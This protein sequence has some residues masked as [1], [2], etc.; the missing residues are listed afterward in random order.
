MLTERQEMTTNYQKMQN[1][2]QKMGTENQEITTEPK[3]MA[4]KQ[5]GMPTEANKTTKQAIRRG[6][7]SN[8]HFGTLQLSLPINILYYVNI[9]STIIKL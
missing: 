7:T 2:Q 1:R 4:F 6:V 8:W 3:I 9:G 5:R